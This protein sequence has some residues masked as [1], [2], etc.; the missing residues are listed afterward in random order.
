MVELS[1]SNSTN[2]YATTRQFNFQ[3]NLPEGTMV[4]AGCQVSPITV[5]GGTYL[6]IVDYFG[7]WWNTNTYWKDNSQGQI[8][9]YV[10]EQIYVELLTDDMFTRQQGKIRQFMG[11]LSNAVRST[12]AAAGFYMEVEIP[13]WW[14]ER[15]ENTFRLQ[16]TDTPISCNITINALNAL[17]QSDGTNPQGTINVTMNIYGRLPT[18]AERN[19]TAAVINSPDGQLL[20]LRDAVYQE[21]V[22]IPTGTVGLFTAA[23]DIFKGPIWALNLFFRAYSDVHGSYS[24]PFTNNYT[25]FDNSYKPDSFEIK[26]GNE[27]I[28]QRVNTLRMLKENR[29]YKWSSSLPEEEI[30]HVNLCEF[31]DKFL[32]VNSSWLDFSFLGKPIINLYFDVPTTVDISFGIL[33]QSNILAQHQAGAFKSITS[34]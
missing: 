32:T 23:I 30:V 6:S 28:I 26:S 17:I 11:N 8:Q 5:T 22:K 27:N 7:I 20:Q 16:Q 15:P 34:N 33:A 2:M 21:I 31:P 1:A 25:N 19:T 18:E 29:L 12:L 4:T 10:P 14:N 13:S 24:T 9:T 3:Q